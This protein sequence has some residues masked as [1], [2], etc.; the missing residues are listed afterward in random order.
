M[1]CVCVPQLGIE[2]SLVEKQT[3]NQI[4]IYFV[5]EKLEIRISGEIEHLKKVTDIELKVKSDCN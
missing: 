2:E 4:N 1:R 3:H 5:A